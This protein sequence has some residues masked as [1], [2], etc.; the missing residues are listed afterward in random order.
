MRTFTTIFMT[1][2]LAFGLMAC[3][4]DDKLSEE[5]IAELV[6]VAIEELDNSFIVAGGTINLSGTIEPV[7]GNSTKQQMAFN[8]SVGKEDQSGNPQENISGQPQS[9]NPNQEISEKQEKYAKMI[10][11]GLGRSFVGAGGGISLSGMMEPVPG[12]PTKQQ[13]T[14][15]GTIGGA[16]T[17]T[18]PSGTAQGIMSEEELETLSDLIVA[19]LGR[20]F[21]G[22]GG[23][24]SLAGIIEPTPLDP[25]IQ[26]VTLNGTIGDVSVNPPVLDETDSEM[27][28]EDLD[29]IA[30]LVI[31]GLGRS[32]VGS[33][34]AISLA[35]IM[36]P[37]PGNPSIQQITLNGTLG[38]NDPSMNDPDVKKLCDLVIAGLGSRSFIGAGGNI[39]LA[40]MVEP[41]K[42][43]GNIQQIVL[44]GTLELMID[45]A[46]D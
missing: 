12:D 45:E 23:S 26:Q 4:N 1:A 41:K 37:V 27:S 10:V 31:G 16:S 9:D 42:G 3:N 36:E 7:P 2:A 22:S 15:N 28:S 19:G 24:V 25:A 40:G 11:A 14:L 29:T 38:G 32:F 30:G 17:G 33:G 46:S 20:S 34:G 39:S 6:D 43:G 18:P 35:G 5:E 13:I 44:N 21:V 8:G